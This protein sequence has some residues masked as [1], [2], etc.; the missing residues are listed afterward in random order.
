M[1]LTTAFSLLMATVASVPVIMAFD[2]SDNGMEL[3][4]R[5]DGAELP[6]YA[7]SLDEIELL[8]RSLNEDQLLAMR[9][10]VNVWFDARELDGA[11][12]R[13]EFLE[14]EARTRGGS[15]PP[16]YRQHDPVNGSKPKYRTKDRWPKPEYSER[17]P[18]DKGKAKEQQG[19]GQ[20][21]HGR[22]E[23]VEIEARTR[24]GS[25]PPPYRQHDPVNGSKPKYRT[26]DRWPKPEYSERDPKD[27]GKAKEQQGHGQQS[28]GRRAIEYWE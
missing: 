22:R 2:F 28:H 8:V 16:P 9:D 15:P 20:Q 12:E 14:L 1:R 23:F 11:H 7:R 24:G 21:G 27:K 25:P 3:Q 17:D 4:A 6:Q 10:A 19:H 18:K 5:V 26:K 13:R